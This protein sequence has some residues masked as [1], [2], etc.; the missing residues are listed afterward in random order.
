[1]KTQVELLGNHPTPPNI[2]GA[3][4]T[5]NDI[6]VTATKKHRQL[7]ENVGNNRQNLINWFARKL[8]LH[9]YDDI[10]LT[11]LKQKYSELGF[12]QYAEDRRKLPR[13]DATRKGNAIEVLLIEYIEQC[14]GKNLIKHYKLRY[15]PNVDQSIK[16]DDTLLIDIIK[17]Q[18]NNDTARIFLGESKFRGTP[19]SATV[20]KIAESLAET[21]KPLSY[22]FIIA[23]LS[24]SNATKN[25]ADLLDNLILDEIKAKGNITYTGLLVSNADASRFVEDNFSSANDDLVIISIGLPNPQ[26]LVNDA[27]TEAE[28]LILNPHQI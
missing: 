28:R 12:P 1:M 2:F 13:A 20:R 23:E 22:S 25:I 8:I 5:H 19:N 10:S 17:D 3:W 16:G 26:N 11:R 24:K 27:F 6:A 4:L 9:H 15:N 18:Q 21:K 14:Q 7:V